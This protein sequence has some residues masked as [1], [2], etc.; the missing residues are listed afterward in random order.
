MVGCRSTL[1]RLRE[2]RCKQDFRSFYTGARGILWTLGAAP[3]ILCSVDR[4][5]TDIVDTSLVSEQ[6]VKV[7]IHLR[8]SVGNDVVAFV[9]NHVLGNHGARNW[10]DSENV[11]ARGPWGSCI[12]GVGTVERDVV[13]H[14]DVVVK[15]L[16]GRMAMH[17]HARQAIVGQAIVDNH[18]ATI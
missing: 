18:V 3:V 17:G 9:F 10:R 6:I 14:D 1:E 2:P 16:T 11:N 7:W 12:C 4:A 5:F 8:G 13:A 15:V